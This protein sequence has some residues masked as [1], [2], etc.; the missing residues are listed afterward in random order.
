M[1]ASG[2]AEHNEARRKEMCMQKQAFKKKALMVGFF[3][4]LQGWWDQVM[5][6]GNFQC[7]VVLLIWI[8]VGPGFTGFVAGVVL[9]AVLF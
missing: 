8:L 4:W 2:I 1:A 5:V 6:L 9:L 7:P 3:P